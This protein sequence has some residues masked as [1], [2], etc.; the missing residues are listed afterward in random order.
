MARSI[1]QYQAGLRGRTPTSDVA[2]D[3]PLR[4]ITV[5]LGSLRRTDTG[6]ERQVVLLRSGEDG[7]DQAKGG[8]GGEGQ[9]GVHDHI[10]AVLC[11]EQEV[12]R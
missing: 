9:G 4:G 12:K 8:Q 6:G 11:R 5:R 10:E 3:D 2:S 1:W 7:W